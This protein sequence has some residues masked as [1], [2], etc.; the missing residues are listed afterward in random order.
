[1]SFQNTV[2]AGLCYNF[3][4]DKLITLLTDNINLPNVAQ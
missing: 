1:M 2:E 4:T 3:W